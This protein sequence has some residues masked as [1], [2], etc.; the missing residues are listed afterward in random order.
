M[1]YSRLTRSIALGLGLLACAA[2][3]A[4][5]QDADEQAVIDVVNTLFEGMAARDT[6]AMA[7]LFAEGARFAGVGRDGGIH[8]STPQE[9]MN[10]VAGASGPAWIERVYDIEV[11]ID[12]PLA[13]VWTYYTFHLDD[14]F[15]H[16]GYDALQM[17]QVEGTW[18]IVHLADSRRTEGCTH[19]TP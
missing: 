12:G 7:P 18:K 3:P 8:Y 10:A 15:S 13:N 16:C 1:S 5:A 11:R 17:L 4:M 2:T 6:A 14:R 9:F 19:T